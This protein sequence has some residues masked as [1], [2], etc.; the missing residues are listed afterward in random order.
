MGMSAQI[1]Q[2]AT[3]LFGGSWTS[4]VDI[5]SSSDFSN[6]PFLAINSSGYAVAIW[7][8]QSPKIIGNF[9]AQAST[10]PFGGSWSPPVNISNVTITFGESVAVDPA[11]NAIATF[12]SSIGAD[13]LIQSATLPFGG[14]WSLPVDIS[15]PGGFAF[16]SKVAVDQFGN[17]IAVWD[18]LDFVDLDTR[19]QAAMLPFGGTSWNTP[20]NISDAGQNSDFPQIA[21]TPTGYAVVDWTNESL[22][23]IQ[24]TQWTPAPFPPSKF[25]GCINNRIFCVNKCTLTAKWKP[26]ISTNVVS[27]RI[28][29]NNKLIATIP[30]TSR[31]VF[32]TC[33]RPCDPTGFEIEAVGADGQV[34]SR[35]PLIVKNK[36]CGCKKLHPAI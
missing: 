22:Q 20:V 10:L 12:S 2:G 18:R 11:G 13:F 31:L 26:S 9:F 15:L 25:I 27:Y 5:S 34:S 21:M 28:F 36:H 23:V 1:I 24:S 16:D 30:A 4:P 7:T 19:I 33:L 17:A 35:V 3:H 14:S 8:A 32:R 6:I 29:R